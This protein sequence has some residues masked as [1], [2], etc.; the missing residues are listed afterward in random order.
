MLVTFYSFLSK[1]LL[2]QTASADIR[3]SHKIN[4]A[5]PQQHKNYTTNDSATTDTQGTNLIKW[6]LISPI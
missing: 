2:Q 1:I 4:V 6:I 5:N 3:T